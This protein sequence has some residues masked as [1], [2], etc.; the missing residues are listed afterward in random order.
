LTAPQT[1][2][3]RAVWVMI[4]CGGIGRLISLLLVGMPPAPFIGFVALE[5]IGALS[6]LLV[7]TPLVN[8]FTL[9]RRQQLVASGE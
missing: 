4:F 7:H 3:F 5:I 8:R 1:A 6:D 2:L 9:R